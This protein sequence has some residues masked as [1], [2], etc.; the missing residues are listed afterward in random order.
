MEITFNEN[1]LD[2][3]QKHVGSDERLGIKFHWPYVKNAIWITKS[4]A[5]QALW[6]TPLLRKFLASHGTSSHHRAED[7]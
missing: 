2:L 4:A 5:L 3:L 1:F 6:H 7:S